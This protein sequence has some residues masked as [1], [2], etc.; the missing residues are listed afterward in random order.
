MS[1]ISFSKRKSTVLTLLSNFIIPKEK[2]NNVFFVTFNLK[3]Q[4]IPINSII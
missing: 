3:S 4:C 2:N 1:L